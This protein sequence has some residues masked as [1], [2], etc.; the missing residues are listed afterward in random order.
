MWSE[1][2]FF[3]YRVISCQNRILCFGIY[4]KERKLTLNTIIGIVNGMMGMY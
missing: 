3:I 2:E 1:A 4:L